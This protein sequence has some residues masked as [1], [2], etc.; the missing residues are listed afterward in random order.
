M[1][2]LMYCLDTCALTY[3]CFFLW[4]LVIAEIRLCPCSSNRNKSCAIYLFLPL[5]YCMEHGG[6]GVFKEMTQS[7]FGEANFFTIMRARSVY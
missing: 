1:L 7:F 3:W 5:V 4:M 6:E 2:V